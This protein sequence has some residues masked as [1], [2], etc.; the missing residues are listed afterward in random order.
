[1]SQWRPRNEHPRGYDRTCAGSIWA[2][3]GGAAIVGG[4]EAGF[5]AIYD[6]TYAQI[7]VL[8]IVWALVLLRPR[9]LFSGT[10]RR[11]RR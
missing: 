1:M 8:A 11:W 9:G 2:A 6:A 3:A 4:W 5:T 7:T 10:G